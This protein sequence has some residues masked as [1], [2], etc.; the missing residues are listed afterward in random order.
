MQRFLLCL[1][2][3]TCMSIWACQSE[4]PDTQIESPNTHT[5][6]ETAAPALLPLPLDSFSSENTL[7]ARLFRY[8]NG[9]FYAMP[10]GFV[11]GIKSPEAE[12][13]GLPATP[14]GQYLHLV[15]NNEKHKRIY[16]H[17][18]AL[19]VED[20]THLWFGFLSFSH[21]LSLSQTNTKFARE[22]EVQN[23]QVVRS[24]DYTAPALAYHAPL[25]MYTPEDTVVL[26]FQLFNLP[27]LTAPYWVRVTL[28]DQNTYELHTAQPHFWTQLPKGQYHVKLELIGPRNQSIYGPVKGA[29]TVHTPPADS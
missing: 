23:G 25:G 20:G 9:Y 26:D 28:N 29:F 6:S 17:E 19:Q 1:L 2:S 10:A 5:A 21:H 24:K 8:V 4:R 12:R 13:R 14:K 22:V 16:H 15:L 11:L 18:Q 7:D 3:M 27:E